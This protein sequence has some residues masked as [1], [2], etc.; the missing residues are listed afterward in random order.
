MN[1]GGAIAYDLP[2]HYAVGD[3]VDIQVTTNPNQCDISFV[4]DWLNPPPLPLGNAQ[5]YGCQMG[6]PETQPG[7]YVAAVVDNSCDYRI[8]LH[9]NTTGSAGQTVCINPGQQYSGQTEVYRLVQQTYN[10]SP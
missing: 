8:W 10:Q 5:T 4:V 6:V 9:Q 1:P 7:F 3:T 2:I